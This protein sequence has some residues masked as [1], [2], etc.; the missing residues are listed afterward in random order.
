MR[1][2]EL[3]E[4][5][6]V[7]TG[8]PDRMGGGQGPVVVLLHGFGAPG[9]DL[10]PLFRVLDVPRDVRF[11]FPAAPLVL[12][13]RL[14]PE[15]SGRAWWPLD[16]EDLMDIVARG[17]IARLQALDPSGLD[18]SRALVEGLL[19]AVD[20]ELGAAPGSVLLGG[21]SQGAMLSVEVA[22]ASDR[23]LAGLAV[24]S[25]TLVRKAAWAARA[26]RRRGLKVFQSHGR[27]D[28]IVPFSNAEALRD[29]FRE[30]GLDV[31]WFAFNGAHAIPDGAID[32]LSALI[33]SIGSSG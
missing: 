17:E 4:L 22:L 9:E 21:F 27:S 31:D 11:V 26:P 29:L 20:T 5:S 13:S 19:D 6:A 8:G 33:R 2:L 24:M 30:S 18:H 7:V 23:P 32:R 14:P 1:R 12:D 25:G 10:V 16:V 28:P 15:L 3:G